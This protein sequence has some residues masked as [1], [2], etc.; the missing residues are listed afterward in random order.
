[1]EIRGGKAELSSK[2]KNQTEAAKNRPEKLDSRTRLKNQIET[3]CSL[4]GKLTLAAKRQNQ[5]GQS[6]DN[7]QKCEPG[8][9]HSTHTLVLLMLCNEWNAAD[10]LAAAGSVRI[11]ANAVLLAKIGQGIRFAKSEGLCFEPDGRL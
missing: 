5:C 6:A 10:A 7:R 9:G 3:R 1:M 2:S 4:D 8:S 11:A